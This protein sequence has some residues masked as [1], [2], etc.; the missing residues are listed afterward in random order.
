[1][2]VSTAIMH[3]PW[4][5]RRVDCLNEMLNTAHPELLYV[6]SNKRPEDMGW[7][8]WKTHMSRRIWEWSL[9]TGAT[10]CLFLTDDL[11]LHP[12]FYRVLKAMIEGTGGDKI[13]GLLSNHPKAVALYE[14][15]CSWYRCNSWVVGPGYLMPREHL[16]EFLFWWDDLPQGDQASP[17][18]KEYLNDDSS[19]NYWNT[20]FGP[21]ESWHPLPTIIEHRGDLE[22]T[23]G[24]GDRYSRERVSWRYT[25]SVMETKEAFYWNSASIKPMGN[26][27]DP[28]Y[29]EH[30]DPVMLEVGG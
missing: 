24:N 30:I 12:Q 21:G 1:M 7:H 2:I 9:S 14:K 18:S 29:W 3:S 17:L 20:Y 11:N 16:T 5:P 13:I 23:L 19:I 15:G 22:S 28:K 6:M 10:H 25:R 26:L 27:A 4:V 8:E